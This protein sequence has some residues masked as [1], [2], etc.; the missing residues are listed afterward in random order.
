MSSLFITDP[1]L[2]VL[3]E[4]NRHKALIYENKA[5]INDM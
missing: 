1:N 3:N 5:E 2:N 4:G